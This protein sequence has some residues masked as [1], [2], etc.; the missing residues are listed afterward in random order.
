[1][2]RRSAYRAFGF[3]RYRP[4]RRSP[5][6]AGFNPPAG[7]PEVT[8]AFATEDAADLWLSE[9]YLSVA[10]GAFVNP[11]GAKTLLRDWW[12]VWL[13]EARLDPSSRETYEAHGRRHILPAFGARELGSLRRN[14]LQA[15]VNRL[16]L[17]PRT[18]KTVL[19]V[20]QSCLK[21]AVVD[22]LLVRS[23]AVGVKPP[24]AERRRLVVPT[25]EEVDAVAGVMFGRYGITVRLAAEAGLRAGEVLGLRVD[26]LDLLGRRLH[27][28][29][30]AQTLRGGVVVDLP[31]K[32][33]AGY[34]TVPLAEATVEAIA[35]H[36]ATYPAR[37]GL[38]VTTS[39]GAPVRRGT[40]NNAW[41]KAKDR[42][43]LDRPL[44]FHDLRHRY[45]SVLIASG[46]DA[47]TVKTLMGHASITETYDTY[48]H[49]FP[50]QSERA[51]AAI[52]AA[53]H[54]ASRTAPRTAEDITAG[55]GA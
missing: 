14:E 48:G 35:L 9:Q 52:A 46:L 21:A 31:P 13:A 44:R 33:D 55:Q 51:A 37:G 28:S 23:N 32:S 43:G 11:A 12:K 34:R 30:Q 45:A 16:P 20:L 36:L 26:D 15:W 5:Y 29:R 19:A 3:V 54:T 7:G 1:M 27:V 38:V 53:I 24:R 4:G 22:E 39:A 50:N 49:L 10:K 25:G 40:H 47:L 8:R 42:G 6:L 41:T 2:K 18:A 17:A